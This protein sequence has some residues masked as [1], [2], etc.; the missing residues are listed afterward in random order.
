[1]CCP[2]PPHVALPTR[3]PPHGRHRRNGTTCGAEDVRSVPWAG[4]TAHQGR[5]GR[6]P[7]FPPDVWDHSANTDSSPDSSLAQLTARISVGDLPRQPIA[8]GCLEVCC[9]IS[10]SSRGLIPVHGVG[11]SPTVHVQIH[12][13]NNRATIAEP[14]VHRAIVQ[15]AALS[16]YGLAPCG[17]QAVIEVGIV[18]EFDVDRQ[19]VAFPLTGSVPATMVSLSR[20]VRTWHGD[21]FGITCAVLPTAPCSSNAACA[22]APILPTRRSV[23]S[24]A[25]APALETAVRRCLSMVSYLSLQQLFASKPISCVVTR[26]AVSASTGLLSPGVSRGRLPPLSSLAAT[27][28][29]V[30]SSGM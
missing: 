22:V 28:R 1:M 18:L 29:G 26:R 20:L 10:A 9:D 16:Q 12:G 25:T 4:F 14:K 5:G 19:R 27:R 7:A 13:I 24:P 8:I 3:I 21:T 17:A 15:V 11:A 30:N 6:P 2:E 23:V